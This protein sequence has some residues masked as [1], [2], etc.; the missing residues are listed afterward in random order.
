MGKVDW[1]CSQ[2]GN[3]ALSP[4]TRAKNSN[5]TFS[6]PLLS[7]GGSVVM[8]EVAYKYASPTTQVVAG[9]YTHSGAELHYTDYSPTLFFSA[10]PE[11]SPWTAWGVAVC[12]LAVLARRLRGRCR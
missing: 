12:F 7:S 1:T 11:P 9:S 8:V 3:V 10:V 2:S 4:A 6:Q 5:V